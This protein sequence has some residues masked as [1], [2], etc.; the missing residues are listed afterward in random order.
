MN[1]YIK[2][3]RLNV[4]N[5]HKNVEQIEQTEQTEQ[6]E[7]IEQKLPIIVGITG[8]KFN[9]KDTL[10]NHLVSKYNY[11]RIAFA[12]PLKE[13]IKT[14]FN[15]NDEQLYG[16]SKEI[17]DEYWKVAPRT[18]MQYVGTDMFRN[19]IGK[20]LPDIGTNIWIEVIKRKIL[21][22]WKT[23]PNQRIVLTDLRFPNEINLIKELNGI[24]IRV[25]RNIEKSEDEFVVIHESET[26]IDMFKVDYDFENNQS[27]DKLYEQFDKILC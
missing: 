18:V 1:K 17:I 9:G 13:V 15:F 24:I 6:F 21:D 7:Q 27:R 2:Q 4:L 23:N 20:I 3:L 14:V 16:E 26:Y 25:K 8:K 19:Q 10:G 12:D 5:K 22:I 11:V